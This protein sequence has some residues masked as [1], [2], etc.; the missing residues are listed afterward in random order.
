MQARILDLHHA[1]ISKL[2]RLKKE[3]EQDGAYRVAKRIHAVILCAEDE[4]TS[5]EIA[6]FLKAPRSKVSFWLQQYEKKGIERLLE[7]HR[8]GRPSGLSEEQEVQLADIIES[9][10][11]AYGFLGGVWTSPMVTRVVKEEFDRTYHPGHVRKILHRLGFSVQRPKRQL[12]NADVDL[13]ARWRRYKYPLIK[14]KR[15][16]K[17][18]ISSSKTKPASGKIPLS[19]KRGHAKDINP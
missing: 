12:A 7:G 4:L 13:L 8:S 5:G 11:V 1:T 3:A 17:M 10:P 16:K 18:R 6:H 19:I 15:G 2:N 14:K 9:G